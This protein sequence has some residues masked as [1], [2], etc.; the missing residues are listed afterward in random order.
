MFGFGTAVVNDKQQLQDVDIFLY[1]AEEFLNTLRATTKMEDTKTWQSNH[2]SPLT[3]L[4]NV[5][6]SLP[7]L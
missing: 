4:K 7:G 5:V 3:A 6:S 1:N 2:A